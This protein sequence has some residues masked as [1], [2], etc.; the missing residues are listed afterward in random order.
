MEFITLSLAGI[1]V[2][3]LKFV[4]LYFVIRYAVKSALKDNNK[5]V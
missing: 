2:T 1:V 3:L 5:A 4:V